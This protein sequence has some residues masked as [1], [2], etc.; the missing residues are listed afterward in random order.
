MLDSNIMNNNDEINVD[1]KCIEDLPEEILLRIFRYLPPYEDYAS[2][3]LVC[4]QWERLWREIKKWRR[5]TFHSNLSLSTSPVSIHWHSIDPPAKFNLTPRFS[6]SVCYVDSKRM[7]YVFG[8]SRDMATS[9]NDFWRLDLST[10]SWER[11]L[12]TGRYPPPK[13]SATFIDD[14][15]GN[16]ILFGG[17]SM[18]YIDDIHIR[19][20]LH[21]ELHSYSFERNS[22]SLHDNLNEPGP[23]CDHSASMINVNN[24]KRMIVFGGN[25]GTREQPSP[26]QR[27]NDLWQWTDI[28]TNTWTMIQVDGIRP[29]P[30]KGHSQFTLNSE[31][32]FIVGGS[33]STRFCHDVWLF[34]FQT[35]QWTQIPVNN[36]HPHDFAPNNDDSPYCMAIPSCILVTFGRIKRHPTENERNM[37]SQYDFSHCDKKSREE[38][39]LPPSSSSDESDEKTRYP[40]TTHKRS[41]IPSSIKTKYNMIEI[42]GGFQIYRL[43]LSN[44]FSLNPCVTWL[45]SKCTSVFGSPTHSS[46]YYSLICARSELILFGGVEKRKLHLQ[47]KLSENDI[48]YQSISGTLAF[49]TISNIPL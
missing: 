27:T 11:I 4:R 38:L 1:V 21:S 10:R 43:D 48:R 33:S 26:L 16:L 39:S 49:I 35:N 28:H 6:H 47:K 2:V 25:T 3:R 34:S 7:L 17:R 31:N 14:E 46:L 30:R 45:P 12:A 20:Q 29:E 41:I 19:E 13:S 18:I 22:W 9:L 37:Y 40:V 32:I 8:G 23:I 24:Q 15:N 44:I 36:P 5:D 42:S